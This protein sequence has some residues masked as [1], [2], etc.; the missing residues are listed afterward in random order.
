MFSPWHSQAP[1]HT[2]TTP[3][4]S[5]LSQ[6]FGLK[7]S[8]LHCSVGGKEPQQRLL[9]FTVPASAKRQYTAPLLQPQNSVHASS[10]KQYQRQKQC[11]PP[12]SPPPTTCD[13]GLGVLQDDPVVLEEAQQL[14]VS[15]GVHKGLARVL[16][17]QQVAECTTPHTP[18]VWGGGRGD[19][20]E[21]RCHSVQ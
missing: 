8:A 21:G 5:T 9:H 6:C 20:R 18:A 16:A 7:A 2:G 1:I 12:E 13:V 3:C 11:M 4:H 14:L 10:A 17:T 19:A 15:K